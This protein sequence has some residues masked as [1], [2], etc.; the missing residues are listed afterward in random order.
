MKI[1]SHFFA[2]L[3]LSLMFSACSSAQKKA[4]EAVQKAFVQKYPGENDPDWHV[5]ANGN[6]ESNFKV[7]GKSLRADFSPE[8]KWIETER[9]IKKEDLPKAIKDKLK[10]DFKGLEIT[11]IEEVD[12]HSK[13]RF[14][15]IEFKQ[16]GKNKDVE[17]KENGT[18]IN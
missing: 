5:D 8:G 16:K 15:D 17:M 18:I 1:R 13:G 12:H 7:N 9:S 3:F 4:P 2:L 14:Y 6:F 11:E 10:E